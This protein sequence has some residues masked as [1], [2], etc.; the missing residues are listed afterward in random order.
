MDRKY[1]IHEFAKCLMSTLNVDNFLFVVR[2]KLKYYNSLETFALVPKIY[3]TFTYSSVANRVLLPFGL[4]TKTQN[5]QYW[6]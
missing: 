3:L 5:W 4:F 2:E 6:H 1:K